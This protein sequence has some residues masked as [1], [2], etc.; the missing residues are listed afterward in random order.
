MENE[1]E[2][3]PPCLIPDLSKTALNFLMLAALTFV[4]FL[5]KVK[6]RKLCFIPRLLDF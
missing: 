4:D 2:E 3:V 1:Y 6:L 5:D